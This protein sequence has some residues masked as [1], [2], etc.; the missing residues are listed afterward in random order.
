MPLATGGND[1][2]TSCWAPRRARSK[3]P[4]P[5]SPWRFLPLPWCLVFL[6]SADC[7]LQTASRTRCSYTGDGKLQGSQGLV[8]RASP[9]PFPDPGSQS[10][11]LPDCDF[12][13]HPP[14]RRRTTSSFPPSRRGT[15]FNHL[16][17]GHEQV[18]DR[19]PACS[20]AFLPSQICLVPRKI[21]DP[22]RQCL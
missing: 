20:A 6:H 12:M 19:G 9:P 17:W 10:P 4:P 1:W 21:L 2:T 14:P 22:C 15:G 18:G 8:P 7:R 16:P 11:R 13:L 5:P 3:A